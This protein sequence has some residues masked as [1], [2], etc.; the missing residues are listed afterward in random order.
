M[1]AF[2]HSLPDYLLDLLYPPRCLGCGRTS[3]P[4]CSICRH[5]L[6]PYHERL[7]PLPPLQAAYVGYVFDGTLRGA[8]HRLK[9]RRQR[10]VAPV[11]A[12]LLRARLD[13]TMLFDAVL[14]VPLHPSRLRERGFNQSELIAASLARSLG[15]PLLPG[16]VRTE[17]TRSQVGLDSNER[18]QNV[19]NAFVWRRASAPPPRLLIIDDVLTTGATVQACAAALIA[20]GAA[21]VT[22]AAVARS[23]LASLT[24][25][26][27]SLKSPLTAT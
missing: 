10:R 25:L 26:S 14:P 21:S 9:Y 11:L 19:A 7:P 22:A 23:R 20:A 13:R 17:A 6:T 1:L 5:S 15:L 8:V 16:L 27:P 3:I 4:L 2:L 24:P 12:D 18:R